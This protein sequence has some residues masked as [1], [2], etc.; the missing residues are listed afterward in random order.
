METKQSYI[1]KTGGSHSATPSE[2]ERTACADVANVT[3]AIFLTVWSRILLE[4]LIVAQLDL[5]CPVL[6][7]TRWFITVGYKTT[8]FIPILCHMNPVHS[9]TS[10]LSRISFNIIIPSTVRYHIVIP[11]F[12]ILWLKFRIHLL[13]LSFVL[14]VSLS[15]ATQ[16]QHHNNKGGRVK[17]WKFHI[18]RFSLSSY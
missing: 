6:Y 15:C 13:Y 3:L 16:V 17:L 10:Y 4:K 2:S 1:G 7:W 18:M 12:H 11:F 8:L 9:V 14:H 5:K